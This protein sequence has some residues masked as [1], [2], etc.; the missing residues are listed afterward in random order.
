MAFLCGLNA[1]AVEK[2]ATLLGEEFQRIKGKGME[3]K[4]LGW[5]EQRMGNSTPRFKLAIK[6]EME[7]SNIKRPGMIQ[8]FII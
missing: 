1:A 3:K 6:E 5:I 4:F 8:I 7:S 2:L